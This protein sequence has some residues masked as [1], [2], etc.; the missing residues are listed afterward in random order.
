MS[1]VRVETVPYSPSAVV[2]SVS[3]IFQNTQELLEPK[4]QRHPGSENNHVSGSDDPKPMVYVKI[5]T[6]D[7]LRLVRG[8]TMLKVRAVPEVLLRSMIGRDVG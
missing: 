2:A 5:R 8:R 7:G 4:D 6:R 3:R 1:S